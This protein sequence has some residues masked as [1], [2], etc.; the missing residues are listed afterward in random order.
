MVLYMDFAHDFGYDGFLPVVFY[1]FGQ[2]KYGYVL[3]QGQW[4][5][6]L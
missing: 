6:G 5:G 1:R 4:I 2:G 3:I